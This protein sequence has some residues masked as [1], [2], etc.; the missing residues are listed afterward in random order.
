MVDA[1]QRPA[2]RA[3]RTSPAPSTAGTST[4]TTPTRWTT[5]ATAPAGPGWPPPRPTTA[6]G[7]AGASPKSLLMAVKVGDTYVVHSENLAQGVVYAADHGADVINTSLGATGN[8]QAAAGGRD[9]RLLQGRVLGGG[10]RQRVLHPP[11]L[12]DQ[13]GHGRRARA[14]SARELADPTIADLPERRQRRRHQLRAR[15]S[16]RQRSCRRSTTPTTAA[17]RPSPPRST[18]VGTSLGDTAY[19]LHQSG[20]STATP[21]LAAA[22]AIVRSAGFRAGLCGGHAEHR[23][24]AHRAGLRPADRAAGAQLQRGAPAARLHGHARPQRRR[25]ERDEQLPAQ[26]DAATRRSAGGEYYPQQGGDPQPRVEHLVRLR[27]PGHLRRRRLRRAGPDPARGAAVRRPAAARRP[28]SPGSKGPVPFAVYDPAKTPTL[29]IVGHVAAPRLQSGQTFAWKVQVAPCLEPAEA[30]FVDVPGGSGTRRRTACSRRGRCRPRRPL[31]ARTS[32]APVSTRS[33]SPA[34]TRS[35]SLST[36]DKTGGGGFLNP[37]WT[38]SGPTATDQDPNQRAARRRRRSTARTGASSTSARTPTAD[39]AGSPYYLG[40]SGEGSPTLYDLEGRGELDVDRG[41]RPTARCWRCDPTARTSRA[42]RS[43]RDALSAPHNAAGRTA[44][45]RPARS[46]ARWRSATSTATSSRRSWPPASRA[47]STPGTATAP[48]S[49]G[50]PVQVPPVSQYADA[51]AALASVNPSPPFGDQCTGPHPA[52]SDQRYSDYGS[53]AAPVLANLENRTDGKLDIVQA[54]ANQCVYV[55]GPDGSV[56]GDVYPNDPTTNADSRRPRS[57]TRRRSATSTTTGTST[58]SSAPRRSRAASGNTSG[59]IYA[60]DGFTLATTRTATPLPGWPVTLPSLAASG[61]PR[62]RPASS[63]RRRCS[64]RRPATARSRPPPACSWRAATP[65]IPPSRSTSNGSQGTILQTD[66]PGRRIQLHRL[67]VPLGGRADRGRAAR[68]R[69]PTA[70]RDRRAQHPDRHRHR[71]RRPARSPASST[72]SAR[73]T[74]ATGAAVPTFPRQIEDWQFLSGPA[75]AD[76]KGDG[77]H[78]VIEGSGGGFVHAFDPASPPVGAPE[79]PLDVV[80]PLRRRRG[81]ERVPRV[82]RAATSPAP[83]RSGSSRATGK[84]AVATVTRDGYLFLT[85][86]N[87]DAVGQRPV[88]ALP[89][90]RAQHRPVRARHAAAGDGRRPRRSRPARP[91]QR[92]GEVDRGRRRLVGRA[93]AE[94]QHRPPLVD[95]ADH[96]RQLRCGHAG[97]AA[98]H[99]RRLGIAGAGDRDRPAEPARRSTSPSARP[100]TPATPA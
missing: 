52:T 58:S 80:E 69:R 41:R 97:D 96:R 86:T 18:R 15:A 98:G 22:G 64:R 9:L 12:P 90:R 36:V 32:R 42:G 67:A 20:T 93:D 14:A 19:G 55:V 63:P 66:T 49:P 7:M 82:H 38:G 40:A 6:S 59:R 31:P 33:R 60:F 84:V 11:Q 1:S 10:D 99:D 8:S 37:T 65:R 27:P 35:G 61:V 94:R 5:S 57:P 85:D 83:R 17:S 46:S 75:I 70:G 2:A 29:T 43:A 47:A 54:A 16:R 30:D 45:R 73:T 87:G 28:R 76:V 48:A 88:V 81:A 62:W 21:H 89:P 51:A 79:Q 91:G 34:P 95:V 50:F 39:H 92:D 23:R 74:P 3:T 53:I 24:R 25:H 56:L 4:T 78:Q 44:R 77:S 68:A 13:P 26:P 71:R 100:T 72:R